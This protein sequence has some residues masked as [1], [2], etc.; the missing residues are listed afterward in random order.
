MTRT[1]TTV[2]IFQK[3]A[4]SVTLGSNLGIATPPL[5]NLMTE[6]PTMITRNTTAKAT[7]NA[8]VNLSES[9]KNNT[10]TLF[11]PTKQ[12]KLEKTLNFFKFGW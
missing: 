6:I 11:Q 8:E 10:L 2:K 1:G 3:D 7:D 12:G 5:I 4:K 9:A